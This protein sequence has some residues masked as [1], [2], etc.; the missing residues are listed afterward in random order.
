MLPSLN[1]VNLFIYF[2]YLEIAGT[3]FG[4][5]VGI[6]GVIAAFVYVYTKK[7]R[8]KNKRSKRQRSVSESV[9]ELKSCY[10][11]PTLRR[12]LQPSSG[13]SD[14]KTFYIERVVY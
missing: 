10:Q 7:K 5:V 14:K 3:T 1:K 9:K 4:I 8:S 13:E 11:I 12:E 2:T 6:I